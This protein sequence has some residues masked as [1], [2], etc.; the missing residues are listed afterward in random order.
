MLKQG[1]IIFVDLD[2]IKGHEQGNKRP[3]LVISNEK[4]N[5]RVNLIVVCPITSTINNF[6]LHVKLPDSL[7]TK[8]EIKCEQVRAVD[9]NAREYKIIETVPLQ[10]LREA[11]D[12]VYG[13]IEA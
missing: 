2:P 4:Y 1:D 8:G 10:V 13:S 9:I 6:P 11:I 5:K 12:I 7:K 3:A